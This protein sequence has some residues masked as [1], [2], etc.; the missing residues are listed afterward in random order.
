MICLRRRMFWRFCWTF[1]WLEFDDS[2]NCQNPSEL[3]R[4]IACATQ[5]PPIR[6]IKTSEFGQIWKFWKW[7][8]QLDE[9]KSIRANTDKSRYNNE[10][11]CESYCESTSDS[12]SEE[13]WLQQFY[14]PNSNHLAATLSQ[15]WSHLFQL[16]SLWMPARTATSTSTSTSSNGGS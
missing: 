8:D 3:S 16:M 2:Q 9:G 6:P 4:H 12:K 11:N 5:Y 14:Q 10:S 1:W 13:N 15:S 7:H